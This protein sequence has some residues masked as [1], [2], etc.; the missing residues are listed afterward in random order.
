MSDDASAEKAPAPG[1]WGRVTAATEKI[2]E[3]PTHVVQLV[4]D[5]MLLL[6]RAAFWLVKPPFRLG[7]FFE[8]AEFIGVQSLLIV[9]MIGT[10]VG[11]VFAL[12]LTSALRQFGTESFVGATL[13]IALTRELA[14][15][16]T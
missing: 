5:H 16:F 7:V 10:F 4:G 2:W 11:M 3:T 8:A 6:G 15:V 1:L 13:G 12:Q 9:T 14:P